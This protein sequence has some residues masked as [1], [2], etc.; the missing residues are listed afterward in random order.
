MSNGMQYSEAMKMPSQ[1]S[2]LANEERKIS[3]DCTL[4]TREEGL[5]MLEEAEAVAEKFMRYLE[6]HNMLPKKC[7]A[8]KVTEQPKEQTPAE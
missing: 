2:S 1:E 8:R 4:L 5:A 7:P 6:E 3:S